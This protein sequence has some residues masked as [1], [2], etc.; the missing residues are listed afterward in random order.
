MV[1]TNR[2]TA[3]VP[4]GRDCR[5]RWKVEAIDRF[6]D[7]SV[8]EAV[9]AIQVFTASTAVTW[10]TYAGGVRRSVVPAGDAS[11][12][13]SCTHHSEQPDRAHRHPTCGDST[14]SIGSHDRP[15]AATIHQWSC[16]AARRRRGLDLDA[17]STLHAGCH[18]HPASNQSGPGACDPRAGPGEV[19]QGAA[20]AARR[21]LR[22]GAGQ[23]LRPARLERGGQDHG[24]EDPVH[25]AQGRHRDGP[26]QRLRCRGAG[27]RRARVHQPHRAVRGGRR[28]PQR[29][30][31]PR[32]G[33]QAEAPQGPGRDRG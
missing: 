9:S 8:P 29:A 1:S 27:R 15:H 24:G 2:R 20:R 21:G 28:D 23:H 10:T 18:E 7:V 3:G 5:R 30:G 12:C 25:A 17:A 22:G 33:R 32:P 11:T 16:P 4:S 31:E 26:G 14:A 19:V 13:L 6:A